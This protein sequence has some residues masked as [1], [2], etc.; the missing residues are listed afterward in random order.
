MP[1]IIVYEGAWRRR[2]C[3]WLCCVRAQLG[4]R[5]QHEVSTARQLGVRFVRVIRKKDVVDAVDAYGYGSKRLDWRCDRLFES[6]L[7]GLELTTDLI[8]VQLRATRH[9]RHSVPLFS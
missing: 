9:A 4:L 7:D 6:L 1:K 3:T 5:S 8:G 2:D